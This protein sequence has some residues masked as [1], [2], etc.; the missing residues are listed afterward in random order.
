MES[1]FQFPDYFNWPCFFTI[2]PNLTTRKRQME[3]WNDLIASYSKEKKIFKFNIDDSVDSELFSN[4]SI[5]RKLGKDGLIQVVDELVNQGRAEY[6]SDA[7]SVFFVYWKSVD[8]WSD[9][10]LRWVRTA[11]RVGSVETINGLLEG[12]ETE[13]EAFTILPY[14]IIIRVLL[15]MERKGKAELIRKTDGSYRGVKFFEG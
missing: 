2:Q 7:K 5:K 15:C 12:E 6:E 3:Q 13:G 14:E 8:E 11:G 1:G 4:P 10:I 9:I